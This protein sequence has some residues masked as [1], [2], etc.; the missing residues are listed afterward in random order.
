[1]CPDDVD[2]VLVA[3]NGF[4]AI[5]A[6]QPLE[7]DLDRPVLTANQTCLWH[8]LQIAGVNTPV[9]GYGRLY[10]HR[11]VSRNELRA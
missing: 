9:S 6:I 1:M 3:G 8:C 10:E 11:Q 4:R 2:G 5:D 7:E